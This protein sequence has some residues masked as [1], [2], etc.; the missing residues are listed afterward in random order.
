MGESRFSSLAQIHIKYDMTVNLEEVVNLFEGLHPR[1]VQSRVSLPAELYFVMLFLSSSISTH[2]SFPYTYRSG[3][4]TIAPLLVILAIAPVFY[5]T[6]FC[7]TNS[8][9]H[10][11]YGKRLVFLPLFREESLIIQKTN[12]ICK[13]AA[14][15]I[16]VMT[17]KCEDVVFLFYYADVS[18]LC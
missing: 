10:W 5:T 9:L 6:L 16:K 14:T 18:V 12:A 4:S 1:I 3:Y 15:E 2:L 17:N 11:T 8:F 7:N 13:E